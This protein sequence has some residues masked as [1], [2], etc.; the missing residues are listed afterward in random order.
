MR[1]ETRENK[2]NR[3]KKK[4]RY[5]RLR[6]LKELCATGKSIEECKLLSAI[7]KGRINDYQKEQYRLQKIT[8]PKE[9]LL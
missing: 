9:P 2:E 1:T 4:A 8:S 3:A 6:L 7:E 5:H